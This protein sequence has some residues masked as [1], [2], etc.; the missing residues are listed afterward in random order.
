MNYKLAASKRKFCREYLK[1][2]SVERAAEAAGIS[3]DTAYELLECEAVQQELQRLR[4]IL[5]AG[6]TA[7]DVVRR[8][9]GLAFE[10]GEKVA[11]SDKLKLLDKLLEVLGAG[12]GSGA[13][14]LKALS[15]LG[16]D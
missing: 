9:A 13:E 11:V 1:Y 10:E 14:F 15:D 3:E 7:D 8:L 2:L 12:S 5:S 4:E 6:I 16:A